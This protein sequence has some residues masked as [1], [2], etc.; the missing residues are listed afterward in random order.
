[1]PTLLNRILRKLHITPTRFDENDMINASIEDQSRDH[2][3]LLE[4]LQGTLSRRLAVSNEL[5]ESIRIARERTNS[6]A[7]F[8]KL[9]IRRNKDREQ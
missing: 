6:F 7:D 4:K 3:N 8:E 5:R 1:M 9:T 2:A